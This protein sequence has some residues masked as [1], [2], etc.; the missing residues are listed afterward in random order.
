MNWSMGACNTCYV[1]MSAFLVL[2]LGSWTVGVWD[3]NGLG[4]VGYMSQILL[5][6]SPPYDPPSLLVMANEDSRVGVTGSTS[7]NARHVP[8]KFCPPTI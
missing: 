7:P 5:V 3:M 6:A 1:L 2:V 8:T 4:I